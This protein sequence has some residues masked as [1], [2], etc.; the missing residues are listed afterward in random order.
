MENA[1]PHSGRPGCGRLGGALAGGR[2]LARLVSRIGS[3]GE[4]VSLRRVAH[5]RQRPTGDCQRED[6]NDDD[7]R[8]S[9][10]PSGRPPD[11]RL[12]LYRSRSHSPHAVCSPMAAR[13]VSSVNHLLGEVSELTA[14]WERWR[15]PRRSS[16]PVDPDLVRWLLR[17][18]VRRALVRGQQADPRDGMKDGIADGRGEEASDARGCN[19]GR[20]DP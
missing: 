20:P 14:P 8:M 2:L 11:E 6:D 5:G 10:A 12:G 15:R 16:L 13:A 3:W 18:L 9:R 19:R 17:K 1:G 4:L 7:P